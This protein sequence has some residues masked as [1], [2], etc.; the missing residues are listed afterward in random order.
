MKKSFRNSSN[1]KTPRAN[2]RL[3]K[4]DFLLESLIGMVLMAIIGLGV[5]FV[6]SR[7]TSSQKDMRLQEITVNKLREAL[8][9]N[10][11][12]SYNVCTENLDFSLPNSEQVTVVKQGCNATTNASINGVTIVG[13]PRPILLKAS[14]TSLGEIVV[15]GT[16]Q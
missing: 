10:G 6:T 11:T 4:G 16:W 1:K 3:Q 5:V 9:K 15:G 7:V 2:L 12:D 14:S 8:I 13:I